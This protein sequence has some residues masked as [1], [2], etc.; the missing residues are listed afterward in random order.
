LRTASAARQQAVR[1]QLQDLLAS[2]DESTTLAGPL[3]V[4]RA[5]ESRHGQRLARRAA[6]A[7]DALAALQ[8]GQPRT[9]LTTTVQ[10]WQA[11]RAW[12]RQQR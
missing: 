4:F 6:G 2:W 5:L 9:G 8:A 12:Q 3:S 7:P 1:A 11:A 10:A